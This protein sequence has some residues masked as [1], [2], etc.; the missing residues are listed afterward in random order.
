[1]SSFSCLYHATAEHRI[2]IRRPNDCNTKINY[3]LISIFLQILIAIKL[4]NKRIRL[5]VFKT[6]TI[7]HYIEIFSSDL[8]ERI[9]G[10]C[11]REK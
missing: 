11:C 5:I 6:K 8:L 3:I 10:E 2:L 1:M 4:R 9:T 7:L